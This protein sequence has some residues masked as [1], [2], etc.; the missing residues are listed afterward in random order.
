MYGAVSKTQRGSETERAVPAPAKLQA[1]IS[2]EFDF[3]VL[4]S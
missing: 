4:S 1:G 3:E 2:F